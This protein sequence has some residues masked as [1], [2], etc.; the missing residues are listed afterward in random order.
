[1]EHRVEVTGFKRSDFM[2][3]QHVPY[4]LMS[5]KTSLLAVRSH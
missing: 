5:V 3:M 1:M 4:L 2:F